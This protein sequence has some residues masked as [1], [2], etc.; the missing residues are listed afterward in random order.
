MRTLTRQRFCGDCLAGAHAI[1][2]D[3]WNTDFGRLMRRYCVC[4]DCDCLW[5]RTWLEFPQ[6]DQRHHYRRRAA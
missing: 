6:F 2:T 3:H 4:P 5:A 1:E